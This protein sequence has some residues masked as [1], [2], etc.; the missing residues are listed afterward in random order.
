VAAIDCSGPHGGLEI[1][2]EQPAIPV[3]MGAY[4][5]TF[6][7]RTNGDG[8]VTDISERVSAAIARSSI[9]SGI[10]TV[11]TPS[12][13]AAIVANENEAGLLDDLRDLL[14]RVAPVG[15]DYAHHRAW[16][17]RNGHSHLRAMLLGPSVV[18]P[19]SEGRPA[20]GRWQQILFIELDTRP[21]DRTVRVDLVGD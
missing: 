21:R 5:E 9:R 13:T 12:S 20:L 2:F 11:F 3:A 19:V 17:E 8:H 18:F 16:G 4:T 15:V 7:L 10:A 14:S 6:E 1:P